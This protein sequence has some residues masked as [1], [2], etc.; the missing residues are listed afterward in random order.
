LQRIATGE[1]AVDFT[2][3]RNR[4]QPTDRVKAGDFSVGEYQ[5]NESHIKINHMNRRRGNPDQPAKGFALRETSAN[6]KDLRHV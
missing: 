2:P 1:V 5:M 6:Q 4:L 3:E